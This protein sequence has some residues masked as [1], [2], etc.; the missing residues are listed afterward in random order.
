VGSNTIRLEYDK[1]LLVS[2]EIQEDKF[3]IDP[4]Y[5]LKDLIV[6]Y[7]NLIDLY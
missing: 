3:R 4:L 7:H 5:I 2:L 1:I 6:L